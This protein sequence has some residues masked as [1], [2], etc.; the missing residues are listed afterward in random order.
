MPNIHTTKRRELQVVMQHMA[1]GQS[2]G[3]EGEAITGDF[4]PGPHRWHPP[5]HLH[6]RL[7]KGRGR[8][9]KARPVGRGDALPRTPLPPASAL[10]RE[11]VL[12]Q[13]EPP[14]PEALTPENLPYSSSPGRSTACQRESLH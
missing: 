13:A 11:A 14:F 1:A 8:G 4:K 7:E 3:A 10:E 2:P 9:V 6:P 5:L 12:D